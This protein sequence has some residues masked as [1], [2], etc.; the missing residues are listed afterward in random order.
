MHKPGKP[1]PSQPGQTNQT[2]RPWAVRSRTLKANTH[3]K[4]ITVPEL[5]IRTQLLLAFPN[6]SERLRQLSPLLPPSPISLTSEPPM[7]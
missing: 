3:E 2:Q 1:Q 5:C 6:P 4:N 7:M